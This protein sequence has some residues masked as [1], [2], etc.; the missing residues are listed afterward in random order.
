[1]KKTI[2]IPV[3]LSFEDSDNFGDKE[4][5][6]AEIS[7]KQADEEAYAQ[8]IAQNGYKE[9]RRAEYPPIGDQLDA[10]W[11]GGEDMESMR[12]QVMAVKEKHPK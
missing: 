7:Q 1:M 6:A 2:A 4:M 5:S 12:R 9:R 11:K 8:E 3:N 10:I